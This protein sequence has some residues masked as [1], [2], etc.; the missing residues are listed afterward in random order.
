MGKQGAEQRGRPR[1]QRWQLSGRY[2]YLVIT[3]RRYGDHVVVVDRRDL[4]LVSQHR[5]WL[6]RSKT[7]V[8]PVCFVGGQRV[9]M[10]KLIISSAAQIDHVDGNT[11]NNARRN[12]RPATRSV[13][14][15]NSALTPGR[16]GER[17]V[18]FNRGKYRARVA[19]DGQRHHL[20]TFTTVEEA[21]AS[22]QDAAVRLYG[23]PPPM[24]GCPEKDEPGA[25]SA[26]P[27]S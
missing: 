13:N 11:C 10:H 4:G 25:V 9:R 24:A 15:Y 5:W 26:A 21:A 23:E 6:D 17:G 16:T 20:G 27:G 8:Y 2:A 19:H 3:S 7:L 1:P 22:Y 14:K 12:L 18:D